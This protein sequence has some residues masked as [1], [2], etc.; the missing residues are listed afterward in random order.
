MTPSFLAASNGELDGTYVPCYSPEVL[1]HDRTKAEV[2]FA[3]HAPYK[4]LP[5]GD[6]TS[7]WPWT[8]CAASA[9]RAGGI[10]LLQATPAA[11]PVDFVKLVLCKAPVLN[12]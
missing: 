3:L 10:V 7:P 5:G 6:R 9:Q 4:A 2:G 12:Q 11:L 8:R 1:E